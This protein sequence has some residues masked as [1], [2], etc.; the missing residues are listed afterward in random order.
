MRIL[1]AEDDTDMQKILIM[2][3]KKE[4]YDVTAVSDGKAALSYLMEHKADLAV[5]DWMMPRMSGIDVCRELRRY[6]IPVKVLMLTAKSGSED[7][8]A[9]LSGGADEYMHK[10]FDPRILIL[11]IKK[12]C[13]LESV[14][15]CAQLSLNQETMAVSLDGEML[16]LTKK[17]YELLRYLMMNRNIVLSREKLLKQV[18]GMDYDGDDRTVDTHIRRLRSKIGEGF[19]TTHV[20]LGYALEEPHD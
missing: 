15:R 1:I 2:Y 17:E 12:L 19:I 4:G 13:G 18:W 16:K 3:L 14:L 8:I 7:E 9:G 6:G 11:R 10:P 5:L 20:G